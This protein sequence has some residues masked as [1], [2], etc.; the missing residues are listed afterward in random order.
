M[1]SQ[2][3]PVFDISAVPAV[4]PAEDRPEIA[5]PV[6][7]A[8]EP[9]SI[10]Y[11]RSLGKPGKLWEYRTADGG[12]Y[13]VV[14]R[15]DLADGKKTIRPCIWNGQTWIM[16]GFGNDRPLYNLPAIAAHPGCPVLVVEGE[17][18]A[19]AAKAFV[20][21]GWQVTC[22]SGGVA[23]MTYHDWTPL[24]G[25][26]VVMWPDNDSPG[27]KAMADLEETL[28]E[29]GVGS[30]IVA[31]P[32]GLPDKWDLADPLPRGRPSSITSLL[33]RTLQNVRVPETPSD[34]GGGDDPLPPPEVGIDRYIELRPLGYDKG[35]FFIL[36]RK[37]KQVHAMTARALLTEAGLMELLPDRSHWDR[38]Y[39]NDKGKI[40]WASAGS[41]LMGQC[42]EAGVYDP[43]RLRGR[44][45]W[46]DR[47][48]VVLHLGEK[49][50]VDGRDVD[51]VEI[52]SEYIYECSQRLLREADLTTAAT[53]AESKALRAVCNQLRW[54]NPLYG[55]LLA[56][57]VATAPVC[58]GLKWRTH[59]WV[60]GPAGSGKSTVVNKVAQAALGEAAIYP[61]GVSSEAGIRREIGLD[62]RPVVF[63]EAE[64]GVGG[65]ERRQA[66]IQLM[67]QAA[68]DGAG[69][70]IKAAAGSGSESFAIR[71]SFLLASIGVGIREAADETRTVVLTLRALDAEDDAGRAEQ[72]QQWQNFLLA[73]D[74]LPADLPQRL[75][76][77][78]IKLLP[79]LRE[80]A[81]TFARLIAAK[82]GNRR[83][84]DQLGTLLAGTYSLATSTKIS[85]EAAERYL[86]QYDWSE[87]TQTKAIRE[88][89]EIVRHLAAHKV[90]VDV[91]N[92]NVERTIG[93]LISIALG[94]EAENTVMAGAANSI[95]KRNGIR[96]ENEPV[97][98][99]C[100]PRGVLIA[101]Q[102][103]TLDAIMRTSDYAQ[104]YHRLLMR[105]EGA[106]LVQKPVR[107]AGVQSRAVFV[108]AKAFLG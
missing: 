97:A 83:V 71:S 27:V 106:M 47:K 55:D 86:D 40:D 65:E 7:P 70:I 18:A 48:R 87:W 79:V 53:D 45:V 10:P 8:P 90:R 9:Y 15:W 93:E 102:H 5:Q 44:G 31:L 41:E 72:E 64:A 100:P 49:L 62:A 101:I 99:D 52:E 50:L 35:T 33:S 17:K 25:H 98:P 38:R 66:I 74:R 39:G 85:D 59:A 94:Y 69:R 21:D 104:G 75:L 28:M 42:Y 76:A 68:S 46:M 6:V 81:E 77:R 3:Q 24:I 4:A 36:G 107:F 37:S 67:R 89:T 30:A 13:G 73:C 26:P 60:T 20:P 92:G 51:P 23:G 19:D 56:G 29:V 14:A 82:L 96:A 80:N 61:L 1:A 58:G 105:S 57:W 11:P 88:D 34:G 54:E 91:G 12:L 2:K 108:P 95:L 103:K 22:W 63:D 43:D 16:A 84:G 78:Q 32:A